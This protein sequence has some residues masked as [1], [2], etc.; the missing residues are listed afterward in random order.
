MFNI[1]LSYKNFKT[2]QNTINR[3][4]CE[5]FQSK[6]AQIFSFVYKYNFILKFL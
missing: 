3:M 2:S 4:F 5:L 6:Y 1:S